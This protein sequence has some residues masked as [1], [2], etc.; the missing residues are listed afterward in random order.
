MDKQKNSASSTA[1]RA[2][3]HYNILQCTCL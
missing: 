1:S 2:D 3:K